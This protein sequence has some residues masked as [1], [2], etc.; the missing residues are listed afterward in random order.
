MEAPSSKW[1]VSTLT[2]VLGL[3][4]LIVTQLQADGIELPTYVMAA[5]TVVSAVLVFLKEEYNPSSSAIR[6][7]LRKR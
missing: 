5:T 1:K 3:I 2:S 4:V 7:A 6:A